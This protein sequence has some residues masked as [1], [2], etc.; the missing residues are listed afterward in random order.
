MCC[1]DKQFYTTNA[2]SIKKELGGTLKSLKFGSSYDEDLG[3]TDGTDST[4]LFVWRETGLILFV[5][6][7]LEKIEKHKT[8]VQRKMTYTNAHVFRLKTFVTNEVPES[9]LLIKAKRLRTVQRINDK[10]PASRAVVGTEEHLDEIHDCRAVTTPCEIL[11]G[12]ETPN[13]NS[14]K[15]FQRCI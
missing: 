9:V 1:K 11:T 10:E 13:K 4:D 7:Q 3:H 5:N 14:R 12:A 8:G 15:T 6:F 2:F